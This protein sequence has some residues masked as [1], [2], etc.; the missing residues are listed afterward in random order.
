MS[1]SL[2]ENEPIARALSKGMLQSGKV[3]YNH[4]CNAFDAGK[5]EEAER[6]F[7]QA[8]ELKPT[9]QTFREARGLTLQKQGKLDDALRE[10]DKLLEMFPGCTF[11]WIHKAVLFNTHRLFEEAEMCAHNALL[12]DHYAGWAWGEKGFALRMQ[13]KLDE[14]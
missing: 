10:Y 11:A 4:G 5:Y 13:H 9:N 8:I 1:S 2:E 14:R 6:Y 12:L 7:T 3:L